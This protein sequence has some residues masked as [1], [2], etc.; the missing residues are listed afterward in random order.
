MT[1]SPTWINNLLPGSPSTHSS[2]LVCLAG[3]ADNPFSLNY[4]CPSMPI[5]DYQ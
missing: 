1:D 4:Q 2:L 3:K 5:N